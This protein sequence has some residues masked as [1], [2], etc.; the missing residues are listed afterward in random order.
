MTKYIKGC[1]QCQR[2]KNQMEA[3]AEK[4]MPNAILTKA[5]NH[6]SADFITKLPLA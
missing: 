2:N 5:W 3:L 6:I 1:D 4:L